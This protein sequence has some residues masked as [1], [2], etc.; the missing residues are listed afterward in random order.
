MLLS[1]YW[2]YVMRLYG[3][4]VAGL[5]G[6]MAVSVAFGQSPGFMPRKDA[7]DIPTYELISIHKTKDAK[8][9]TIHDDP[10]GL[11]AKSASLRS[12]IAEAYGFSLGQLGERELIGSQDWMNTQLF[13]VHAK[14]DSTNVDK[15]KAL[16]KA[17]TMMVTVRE[18]A[19]RTP[20]FRMLMLQ[21]LLEDRFQ[22]KMHYEQRVMPIYEMTVAKGG[23][24]MKTAHPTDPEHGSMEMSNGKLTGDNVPMSFIP[25]MLALVPDVERPVV[26]KTDTEGNYDFEVHWSPMGDS[27]QNGT[28][29]SGPALFTALEEQAGLKL[30]AGKGPVWV[31]VVD[32]AEMPPEN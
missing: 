4:V 8:P 12:L 27:G 21:R 28:T 26:D 24:R 11:T 1:C 3:Y 6:A 14:V 31:I 5:L 17:E 16:T 20:S 29:G 9:W 32:H 25:K 2:G 23:V 19:S 22:L 7:A 10:D 18:I 15:L 13:D 30:K